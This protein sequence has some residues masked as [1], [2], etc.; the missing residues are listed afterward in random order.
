MSSYQ[1]LYPLA[2]HLLVVEID[3]YY[4]STST[5]TSA[6]TLVECPSFSSYIPFTIPRVKLE[7]TEPIPGTLLP[8]CLPIAT[9]LMPQF[10]MVG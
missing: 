5:S 10:D 8:L 4:H 2:V 9:L 7:F 3:T 6:Y 1:M